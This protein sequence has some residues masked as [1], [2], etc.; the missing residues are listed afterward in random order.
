MVAIITR[1]KNRTILLRRN[2]ETVLAQTY[3]QWIHVIVNDGGQIDAVEGLVTE[4]TEQYRGRLKVIHNAESVGME[5]ASNIGIRGSESQFIVV[6]DDDDSWEATFLEEAVKALTSKEWPDVKGV[7]CH[8]DIIYEEI[9]GDKV[10]KKR[11]APFNSWIK[12]LDIVALMAWNRFTPVCF[13]FERDVLTD[14]GYFDESLPV[15]GDWDFNIRF[16]LKYEI[17]VIPK[18][19]AYWH[20]R[21]ALVNGYG[22][23]VHAGRDL[24][25]VYRTRIT[26]RWIRHSVN[27]RTLGMGDLF[28]LSY[29][30]EF[31]NRLR[32]IKAKFAR[33]VPRFWR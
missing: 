12:S 28:L 16:L 19:L 29:L 8:T 5:A 24:H 11:Q 9:C 23:S 27:N 15:C 1:T 3:S 10:L 21:P 13:V 32:S 22:N 6:L 31:H 2:I 33:W 30:V 20:Q 26:N 4:Y 7:I 18:V 17:S 14:I 25:A